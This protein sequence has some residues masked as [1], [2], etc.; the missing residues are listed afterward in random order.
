MSSKFLNGLDSCD[1]MTIGTARELPELEASL[2]EA[3]VAY[4]SLLFEVIQA[5]YPNNEEEYQ[6]L[7][8]QAERE[9]KKLERLKEK[10][11]FAYGCSRYVHETPHLA[12]Y[13]LRPINKREDGLDE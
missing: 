7:R 13:R 11:E 5:D 8:E 2:T 9:G 10:V 6:K 12:Q 3:R 4:D 1:V